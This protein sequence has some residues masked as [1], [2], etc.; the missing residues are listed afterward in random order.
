MEIG[1]SSS[2]KSS[3]TKCRRLKVLQLRPRT[4]ATERPLE[5]DFEKLPLSGS[6]GREDSRDGRFFVKNVDTVSSSENMIDAVQSSLTQDKLLSKEVDDSHPFHQ[7]QV[8]DTGNDS[9]GDPESET[10]ELNGLIRRVE[11]NGHQ[12]YYMCHRDFV[13]S[14]PLKAAMCSPLMKMSRDLY[15]P[16]GLLIIPEHFFPRTVN[17]LLIYL[18][19]VDAWMGEPEY[20]RLAERLVILS[21]TL[22]AELL[23]IRVLAE[24]LLLQDLVQRVDAKIEMLFEAKNLIPFDH[25]WFGPEIFIDVR[26][27][28]TLCIKMKFPGAMILPPPLRCRPIKEDID[29]PTLV[30]ELE[31]CIAKIYC[32]GG[33][34][35]REGVAYF[36]VEPLL[37]KFAAA[38]CNGFEAYLERGDSV[39]FLGYKPSSSIDLYFI[40]NIVAV[41]DGMHDT[42]GSLGYVYAQH[43]VH[44]LDPNDLIYDY[45]N[46]H[47]IFVSL[48]QPDKFGSCFCDKV[49]YIYCDTEEANKVEMIHM[50][51]DIALKDHGYIIMTF[52][53]VDDTTI[54]DIKEQL[55]V[56]GFGEFKHVLLK[57]YFRKEGCLIARKQWY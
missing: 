23:E 32:E 37:S 39:L 48:D 8:V 12:T 52:E 56:R 53:V 24:S 46:I 9:H 19:V 31:M 49:G 6:A 42:S 4:S 1:E 38:L 50:C 10:D 55:S 26:V 30:D 11:Q 28:Q 45:D 57:P 22:V 3:P 17:F 44:K 7:V 36:I 5:H 25:P 13:I 41:E 33:V 27:F 35:N 54:A 21:S 16:L 29:H 43:D 47:D 51:A 20:I 15:G 40:A 18:E 14:F 34:L 2:T